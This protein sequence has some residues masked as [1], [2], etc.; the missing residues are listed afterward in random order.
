MHGL[1]SY[2]ADGKAVRTAVINKLERVAEEWCREEWRLQNADGA[3]DARA[4]RCEIRTFGSVRLDV[5]T[6]DVSP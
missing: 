6:P 3:D 1:E 4:P 2:F 5:H